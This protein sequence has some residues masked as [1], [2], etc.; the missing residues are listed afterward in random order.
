MAVAEAVAEVGTVVARVVASAALGRA[1]RERAAILREEVL[2]IRL[3][4]ALDRQKAELA[5]LQKS[6]ERRRR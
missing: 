4:D 2:Q 3:K 5:Q 6:V 1:G